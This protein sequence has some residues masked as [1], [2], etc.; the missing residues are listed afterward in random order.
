MKNTKYWIL[1]T[2][3]SLIIFLLLV[4]FPII[5]NFWLI[6]SMSE[7]T[8]R[9]LFIQ[10]KIERVYINLSGGN[11]EISRVEEEKTLNLKKEIRLKKGDL[12]YN[13]REFGVSVLIDGTTEDILGIV[14]Q[15]NL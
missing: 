5:F 3:F 11:P 7:E 13:Y 9:L 2:A 1:N 14:T 15:G 12:V 4:F 6:N 8:K 10:E